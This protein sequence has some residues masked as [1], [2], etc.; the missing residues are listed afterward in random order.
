MNFYC[1][2]WIEISPFDDSYQGSNAVGQSDTSP[3]DFYDSDIL[4]SIISI[5]AGHRLVQIVMLYSP[6]NIKY[7]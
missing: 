2:K 3:G 1:D 7:L 4:F 5:P 6:V